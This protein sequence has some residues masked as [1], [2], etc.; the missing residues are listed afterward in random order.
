MNRSNLTKKDIFKNRLYFSLI[1]LLTGVIVI[2]GILQKVH[3]SSPFINN[4][5][6]AVEDI[7]A[8][9][10]YYDEAATIKKATAAR[11]N[12]EPVAIRIETAQVASYES[13]IDFFEVMDQYRNEVRALSATG[14]AYD[15]ALEKI[16]GRFIS[17]FESAGVIFTADIAEGVLRDV[18]NTSYDSY[19]TIVRTGFSEIMDEYL[20]AAN[21]DTY[22]AKFAAGIIDNISDDY[23]IRLTNIV[24]DYFI[25]VN[26]KVDA[27]ATELLKAQV[28]EDVIRNSPVVYLKGSVLF[29][30]GEA[31][32]P[33]DI[34]VLIEMGIITSG[35]DIYMYFGAA[36]LF[37]I[38]MLAYF[39]S[40]KICGSIVRF[41]PKS[42]LILVLLFIIVFVPALLVK[43]EYYMYLPFFLLP[44]MVAIILSDKVAYV[45]T[46]PMAIF[47]CYVVG[48]D[49]VYLAIL[50]I[51]SI[52]GIY[53]VRNTNARVRLA[54]SGLLLGLINCAVYISYMLLMTDITLFMPYSE[55]LALMVSS[56]TSALICLAFLPVFEA[57]FNIV[58]PFK[59]MELSAPSRPL[60][61]RLMVEAPGTYHHSL[62]VGN[63]AEEGADAIGANGLLARVGAYYHDIGKLNRPAF[64]G[65]N[66]SSKTG[67]PH[68]TMTPQLSATIITSHTTEGAELARQAKLPP[69]IRDIIQEHHGTT[70]VQYFYHKAQSI[71]D[72]PVVDD[73]YRYS[74]PKPRTKESACVML[75]D[76]CEATIRSLETDNIIEIEKTIRKV[77]KN[78][79]DDGQFDQCDLTLKDLD[80]ILF[81]FMKVFTGYFH[82]RVKYPVENEKKPAEPVKAMESEDDDENSN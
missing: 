67:N 18:N 12:V 48:G 76:A 40:R 53:I 11:D 7:T 79:R 23:L 30:K 51:G 80:E 8:V 63:L 28:Y 15:T 70:Q 77:I 56:L 66:Q 46:C 54:L 4:D 78:K 69:S 17:Y 2:M 25:Q 52:A 65:E 32:D 49:M 57:F 10:D 50:F 64:F 41:A 62:M 36:A 13:I 82:Q 39:A 75:A 61:K 20:Y 26:S 47:Y 35:S 33:A 72:E 81:A 22:R 6:E 29:E 59:L 27:E 68:N 37:I 3:T 60:L 9:S 38:C 58:T 44:M 71:S 31:L 34:R 45:F 1:I 21:L 42:V 16:I 14:A 19:K 24:K 5:N 74:G 55:L 43:S 73:D